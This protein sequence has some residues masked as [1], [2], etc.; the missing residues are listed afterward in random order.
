[1]GEIIE[2]SEKERERR[3]K[4]SEYRKRVIKEKREKAV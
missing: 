4:I 1:M 2:I 3:R